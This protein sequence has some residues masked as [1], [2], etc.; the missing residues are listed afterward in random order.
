MLFEGK[1]IRSNVFKQN[2]GF[3]KKKVRVYM[4]THIYIPIYT[5]MLTSV[6][7]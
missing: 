4:K 1:K 2:Q 3:F 5:H 6:I 7:V